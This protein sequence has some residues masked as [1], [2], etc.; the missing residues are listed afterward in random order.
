MFF[1]AKGL[2][3]LVVAASNSYSAH[4]ATEGTAS[5]RPFLCWK[6]RKTFNLNSSFEF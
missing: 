4:Q 5:G 2:L 6:K 3:L 1:L